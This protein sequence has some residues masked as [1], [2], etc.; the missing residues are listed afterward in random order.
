[1][2]DTVA[3]ALGWGTAGATILVGLWTVV[4]GVL[5]YRSGA[6]TERRDQDRAIIRREA[7]ARASALAWRDYAYGLRRDLIDAGTDP[8]D[9]RPPPTIPNPK[10]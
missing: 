1:M 9:L 10:D 4:N 2:S 8:D 5:R 6:M 7:D 3:Q